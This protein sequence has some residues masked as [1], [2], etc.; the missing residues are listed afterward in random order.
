MERQYTRSVWKFQD[1]LPED[2]VQALAE[3]RDGYL[4]IGT[5][6]GLTRFDGNRSLL[7]G[8]NALPSPSVSSVFR[9]SA[10]Q[11]GGSMVGT[12][13]NAHE[14]SRNPSKVGFATWV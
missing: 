1:G 11:D 14:Q 6:G 9:L 3:T 5:I 4:W 8:S 7:N 10:S 2:T 12:E 13:H